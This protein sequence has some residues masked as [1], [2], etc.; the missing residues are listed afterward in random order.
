MAK[1]QRLVEFN[2]PTI[3]LGAILRLPAQ[4]PYEDVVEFLVFEPHQHGYGLGLMVRSGYKAGLTLIVLPLESTLDGQHSL[5]SAW[6]V[7]NWKKWIYPECA[8]EQVWLKEYSK[9]PKLPKLKKS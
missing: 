9:I 8:V 6:L 2:E 7:A 5:S 4:Y 1:W 3:R